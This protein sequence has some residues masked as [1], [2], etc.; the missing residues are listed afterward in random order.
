ML[1]NNVT[2]LAA[3]FILALTW[4]RVVDFIAHRGWLSGPVSRKIIHAGTGPIFVLCWLFFR[5]VPASR[6]LAAL[7]PF[8]ITLQFALVGLGLW[9]DPAAV[10]AMSRTGDRREILRGPLFYGIVFIIL[11]ILYWKESPI[12]IVALMMLCGGDG[13]ADIVGKRFGKTRLPWSKNKTWAGSLGMFVGGWLFSVLVI[14]VYLLS[15]AFTGSLQDYL[16][17]ITVI[18]LVATAVES[19]PLND[20]DNLTVPAVAVI[21]GHLLFRF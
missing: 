17:P 15:G 1:A 18:S 19:L 5:D 7:V 11:T 2:A 3:T 8:A 9:R 12:G 14:W 20:L 10:Q 13:L 4:L 16:L 21:L 6:F